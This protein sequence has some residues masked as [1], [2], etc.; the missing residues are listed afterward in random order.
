MQNYCSSLALAASA[1]RVFFAQNNTKC[2]ENVK[3]GN[4]REIF[5][6]FALLLVFTWG[7]AGASHATLDTLVHSSGNLVLAVSDTEVSGTE[8]DLALSTVQTPDDPVVK[9]RYEI[10]FEDDVDASTLS[11]QLNADLLPGNPC[12]ITPSV[13]GK[14]LSVLVTFTAPYYLA[15]GVVLYVHINDATTPSMITN[16]RV[17]LGGIVISDNLDGMRQCNPNGPNRHDDQAAAPTAAQAESATTRSGQA[18]SDP[19]LYPS[20]TA[21]GFRV[22]GLGDGAQRLEITGMDGRLVKQVTLAGQTDA[23]VDVQD[24]APGMYHVWIWGAEGRSRLAFLK[25]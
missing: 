15:T 9:I 21:T 4:S 14:R 8:R 2:L 12:S 17:A 1:T 18:A 23:A 16:E 6:R 11:F 3:K 20:V 5:G 22:S 24:L 19:V 7:I 25:E 10:D 13:T